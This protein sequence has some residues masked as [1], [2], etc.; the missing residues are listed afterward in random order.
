MERHYPIQRTRELNLFNE[1][2]A[3]DSFPTSK[4]PVYFRGTTASTNAHVFSI[5]AITCGLGRQLLLEHEELA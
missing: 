3:E 2:P 4:K 5:A 1:F